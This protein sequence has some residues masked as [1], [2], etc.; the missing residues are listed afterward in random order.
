M[1]IIAFLTI[2]V[3][4]LIGWQI[5]QYI[6]SKERM[7]KIAIRSAEKAALMVKEDLKHISDATLPLINARVDSTIH[8]VPRSIGWYFAA[9]DDYS[10]LKDANLYQEYTT[11]LLAELLR[12]VQ[13]WQ[14]EKKLQIQKSYLGSYLSLLDKFDNPSSKRIKE[15]LLDAGEAE[16]GKKKYLESLSPL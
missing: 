2:L 8:E 9:L 5:V 12:Q 13:D 15:L 7:E 10:Q 11:F 6:F 4:L 14:S 16:E 3:T 1:L